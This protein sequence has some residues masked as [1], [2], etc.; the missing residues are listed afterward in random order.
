MLCNLLAFIV[1]DN[2]KTCFH[3]LLINFLNIKELHNYFEVGRFY[4]LLQFV[5]LVVFK[6]KKG[7]ICQ[8]ALKLI[9]EQPRDQLAKQK[10]TKITKLC[11]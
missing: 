3:D 4:S 7:N 11:L 1:D 6:K 5:L 10:Q 8:T 2:L 9:S